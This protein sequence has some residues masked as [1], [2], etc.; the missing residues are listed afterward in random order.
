MIKSSQIAAEF[1]PHMGNNKRTIQ[2]SIHHR[3]YTYIALYNSIF[4]HGLVCVKVDVQP[5]DRATQSLNSQ[6]LGETI[7]KTLL[8]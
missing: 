7:L 8:L 5:G 4:E 3:L 1:V 6:I 2:F